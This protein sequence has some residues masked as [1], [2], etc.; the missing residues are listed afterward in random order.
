M[1]EQ[2]QKWEAAKAAFLKEIEEI[3][4]EVPYQEVESRWWLEMM[5][6]RRQM[7]APRLFKER[8]VQR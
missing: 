8:S 7:V 4:K 1:K 2:K 3:D 6:V 5:R